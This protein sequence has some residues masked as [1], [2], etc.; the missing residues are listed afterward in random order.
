M[1][2]GYPPG[3]LICAPILMGLIGIGAQDRR[4]LTL[5]RSFHFATIDC[6]EETIDEAT[7]AFF[8]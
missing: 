6:D 5:L 4:R 3:A 1:L 7:R 8:K 2:A